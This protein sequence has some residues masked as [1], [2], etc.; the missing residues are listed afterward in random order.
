MKNG[1]AKPESG[2]QPCFEGACEAMDR[3]NI[4]RD[5][6][7]RALILFMRSIKDYDNYSQEQKLQVQE[8]VVQ[9]LKDGDLSE[10]RF[11]QLA[12][13]NEDIL[14]APWRHRLQDALAGLA[15]TISHTREVILRRRGDLKD[16]ESTTIGL[17]QSG[18][19]LESMLEG[20]RTGFQDVMAHMEKDAEDLA[21]LSRTDALTGLG[22]RRAFEE[23]LAK[24]VRR[25]REE[26]RTLCVL[27]ADVDH[28]KRFNDRFGHPVGDQALAAVASVIRDCQ[29]HFQLVGEET[30]CARYGGEEFTVIASGLSLDDVL[31]MAEMI[32][33]RIESYNFVIRDFSGGILNA[34]IRLT[35]SLGVACLNSTWRDNV[36]QR[37]VNAA[38]EALYA[39]KQAGRNR[40]VHL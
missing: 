30:F 28:F 15:R 10:E 20:I 11:A 21:R 33:Q 31:D 29:N 36:E 12:R 19:D 5:S 26:D 13:R 16:L 1:N 25:A 27:M 7:W 34:S 22:N 38:D 9:V 3:A 39:A 4:P 35:I 14:N 2:R 23:A 6:K 24:A 17:V 18:A 8:L 40:V 32:R 37:L